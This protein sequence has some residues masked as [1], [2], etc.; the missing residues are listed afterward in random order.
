MV[1]VKKDEALNTDEVCIAYNNAFLN[2]NDDL[3]TSGM[4]IRFSGSTCV[5]MMTLGQKLFCINVGDSRGIIVKLPG[6][7]RVIAQAISR[8][9][10]PS[11]PDEA[12]RIVASGGRIDSF[13]DPDKNP[14]GPLR[15]WLKTEN[16]PGLAMTRSFGDEVASRVGVTAEPGKSK[17]KYFSNCHSS[18]FSFFLITDVTA[19]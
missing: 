8:D 1:T 6:G 5:S 13:R 9:Q 15:V 4:D 10:K 17:F 7:D 14:I 19:L 16:V 11:Q 3:F 12:N 18:D 2:C